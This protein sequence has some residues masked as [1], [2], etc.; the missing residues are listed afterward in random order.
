MDGCRRPIR[1]TIVVFCIKRE[2]TLPPGLRVLTFLS[3]FMMPIYANS[4]ALTV[5]EFLFATSLLGSVYA[6][7]HA[8]CRFLGSGLWDGRVDSAQLC[9]PIMQVSIRMLARIPVMIYR[10]RSASRL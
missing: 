1:A 6:M 10:N 5:P 3:L 8:D 9:L 2:G 7:G 4:K